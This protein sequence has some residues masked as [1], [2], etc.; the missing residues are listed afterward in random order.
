[1]MLLQQGA[2][3]AP[4]A[5]AYSLSLK[6]Y[7][8]DKA[9]KVRVGTGV[10]ARPSRAQFGRLFGS[11]GDGR[12]RPSNPSGARQVFAGRGRSPA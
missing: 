6:P 12:P 11:C 5:L 8:I 7:H 2:S 10:P 1:M 9:E 4:I 3:P